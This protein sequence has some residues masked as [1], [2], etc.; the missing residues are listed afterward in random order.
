MLTATEM[1][2][3]IMEIPKSK[4]ERRKK[5]LHADHVGTIR[6]PEGHWDAFVIHCQREGISHKEALTRMVEHF[7]DKQSLDFA[8][9]GKA[10]AQVSPY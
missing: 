1:G 4:L 8:Y 3:D 9:G 2:I 10:P 5:D 6:L 7:V